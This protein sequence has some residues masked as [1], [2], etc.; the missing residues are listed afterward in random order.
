[1]EP[2]FETMPWKERKEEE[3]RKNEKERDAHPVLWAAQD[4]RYKS[5]ETRARERSLDPQVSLG[6]A[7]LG[8]G[9]SWEDRGITWHT[10]LLVI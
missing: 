3:K 2:I 6:L 7:S 8:G 4:H 5:K 9:P 10:M 1:M